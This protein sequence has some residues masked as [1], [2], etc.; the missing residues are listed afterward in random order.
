[1]DQATDIFEH[2]LNLLTA[3]YNILTRKILLEVESHPQMGADFFL[4]SAATSAPKS[5]SHHP[6]CCRVEGGLIRHVKRA[7]AIGNE[8]C[9]ALD[10]SETQ[11]EI[12]LA[13]LLLHDI[14]KR[15]DFRT[16]GFLAGE[17][18]STVMA[19]PDNREL[20]LRITYYNLAQ[21]CSC[22]THHMGPWTDESY[23]KSLEKYT[24]PEM[25]TYLSDY[26]AAR[27]DIVMPAVDNF[28]LAP[29]L[30]FWKKKSP[31]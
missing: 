9:R 15:L 22:V 4:K 2:E 27:R 24:L 23:K 7:V 17:F 29:M 19:K 11:R 28:D 8:M 30:N 5:I 25:A 12:V 21:I 3:D 26:T 16:H 1:M 14:A 31:V 10:L 20:L 6:D 13:A 18:I